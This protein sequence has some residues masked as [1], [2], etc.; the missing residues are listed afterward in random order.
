[1]RV[2]HDW[3]A[4]EKEDYEKTWPNRICIPYVK[5]VHS[6]TQWNETITQPTTPA[7]WPRWTELLGREPA[8]DGPSG[9]LNPPL[10]AHQEV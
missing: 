2:V 6:T 4:Q 9:G 3:G 10:V 5:S 1:M 8:P 7:V